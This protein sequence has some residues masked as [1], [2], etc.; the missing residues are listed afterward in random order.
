[1]L[2]TAEL[3]KDT[4]CCGNFFSDEKW[5]EADEEWEEADEEWEAGLFMNRVKNTALLGRINFPSRTDYSAPMF[6]KALTLVNC[7]FKNNVII[8]ER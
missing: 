1:M 7:F 5:E 2:L 6:S 4:L 8:L 3:N